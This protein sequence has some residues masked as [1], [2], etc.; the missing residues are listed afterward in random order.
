MTG[1]PLNDPFGCFVGAPTVMQGRPGRPVVAVKDNIHVAGL[2]TGAGLGRPGTLAKRDAAVVQRLREDGCT[3]IGKTRMDEIAL[4]ATGDNAH[5]GRTENP[6]V[7]GRSPG[8]SSSG[9]AAAVAAGYCDAALGTDTL[10]SVRIPAAYCGV[11]GLK[12]TRGR[13]STEGIVPLSWTLDHVG[14]IGSSADAVVQVLVVLGGPWPSGPGE[15]LRVGVP[16]VLD[17]VDV[18]PETMRLF[19]NTLSALKACGWSV[20]RCH[21]PGWDPAANRRAGLLLLEAEGA[22]IYE[23]LLSSEDPALSPAVR[24]S[25][26]FGRDC[27]TGRL[28]RAL[29]SLRDTASGLDQVLRGQD[30]LALPTVPA[31][32]FAW[33]SGAP[34]N[35]ADLTALPNYGG[36]PAISLPIGSVPDGRPVGLQLIGRLSTDGRLLDA[37]RSIEALL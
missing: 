29:R 12:P 4:G 18:D 25:L 7:P 35:L 15:P 34:P 10:G 27:G 6:R 36:H 16:D 17:T 23:S 13:L 37:A 2:P 26:M 5:Y 28:V 9:S 11:V 33:A 31:P 1:M 14:I 24:R 3:L 8:G 20:E 22:C 32:A 21:V 30:L 19:Q